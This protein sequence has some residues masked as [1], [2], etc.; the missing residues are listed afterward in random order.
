MRG[1][2]CSDSYLLPKRLEQSRLTDKEIT[3]ILDGAYCVRSVEFV[4]MEFQGDYPIKRIIDAQLQKI[5]DTDKKNKD[6]NNKLRKKLVQARGKI[7][8]GDNND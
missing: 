1:K 8:F 3:K 5:A 4:G 2:N 6:R 7:P